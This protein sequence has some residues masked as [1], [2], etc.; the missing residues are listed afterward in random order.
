MIVPRPYQ[1]DAYHGLQEAYGR[2]HALGNPSPKILL[3]SR[4]GTGKTAIAG[5]LLEQVV[6]KRW[7]GA[8]M[9]RSRVLLEQTSRHLDRIGLTDHG[10]VAAGSTRVRP[11]ARLQVCIEQTLTSTGEAPPADVIVT[12]ECEAV[13]C[14]T[15]QRIASAY[16]RATFIGLTASPERSDGR[17]M[18]DFYDEL[19]QVK[20]T[21]ADLVGIG[22]L[23]PLYLVPPLHGP[24]DT[25]FMHPVKA[26]ERYAPRLQNHKS[27]IFAVSVKRA[28]ELAVA[29]GVAGYRAAAVSGKSKAA[30]LREA[31]ERFALPERDP[32][33]LD[34]LTNCDLL[35]R[36]WDS[37]QADV[38]ILE[39]GC[40]AWG[41]YIQRV[42]RFLRP[43]PATGKRFATFVDLRGSVWKCGHPCE[44]RVFSLA[45]S[46]TER[47]A[48]KA[49]L[50]SL[51]S[52]MG[53]GN[54]Y[55]SGPQCCPACGRVPPPA[56]KA[57]RERAVAAGVVGVEDVQKKKSDDF[58]FWLKLESEGRA[59]GHKPMAAFFKFKAIKG[60][61]PPWFKH[62]AR[63]AV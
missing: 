29:A 20:A 4:T 28:G 50:P 53:C 16:P 12:D 46:E 55:L 39:Q 23:V 45:E 26:L 8:F 36:G 34:V 13:L 33:A 48:R 15:S 56:R 51:A 61:P 35:I 5:M 25:V 60:Y 59:R 32:R 37:P 22:A 27:V 2:Q 18:G 62:G 47:N 19:V 54:V 6:R 52:C 41:A 17:P 30:E 49:D 40:T 3:V 42:G 9:V 63:A 21:F 43:S 7:R 10:I 31:F 14:D 38:G 57:P 11:N 1:I 24:T 44:D 58:G